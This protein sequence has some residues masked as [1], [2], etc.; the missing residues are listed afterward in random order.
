M[1]TDE[2][3]NQMLEMIRLLDRTEELADCLLWTGAT[4]KQGYPI[5]KPFKKSCALVRRTMFELH[6]GVLEPRVPIVTTCEEKLCINPLHLKKSTTQA[7]SAAAAKRGAFSSRAR[8]AKISASKRKAG[9]LTLEKVRAI[10]SSTEPGPKLAA[11]YGVD[12]S[13][14]TGIKAGTRWRDYSSHWAGLM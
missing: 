5:Y 2:L 11:L 13:L 6:G 7:V 9:K 4:S 8:A 10:R 12:R 1:S 14:I 3:A